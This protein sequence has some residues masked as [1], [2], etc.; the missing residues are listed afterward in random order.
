VFSFFKRKKKF[1]TDEEQHRIVEAI[2]EA[3]R[4]T[5]G[6]VRVFVESRCRFMDAIDRAAEIFFGL[7][8]DE[9]KDRNAV[10]VYVA[11]VDHQ[12]AIFADEQ[13]H[14]R[15]GQEYWN[16]EVAK[17]IADFNRDDLAEGIRHCVEDIGLS[18]RT[19]FPYN[20]ESDKNELPDE[21]VFG[22]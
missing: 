11:T 22:K 16:T 2:R 12:L 1:F 17:M 8:M 14:Q 9:T 7:E 15:T 21:I 10:L 13:I 6:E 19:H 18:L 20:K 5:S 3:E 4:Q